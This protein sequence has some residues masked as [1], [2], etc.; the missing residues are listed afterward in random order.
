MFNFSQKHTKLTTLY[1]LGTKSED[2]SSQLKANSKRKK[3]V[4][5]VPTLATE[6]TLED[7]RP[8]F[9][10]ITRQLAKVTYL[11]KI[12]FG[13]DKAT[14]EEARELSGLLKKSGLRNYIIQHNEGEAF[15]SIYKTLNEAGFQLDQPGKGR[16]MFMSFG[17]AQAIGA[18]CIGVLDADIKTFH[19][20]QLDRLFYPVL[21]RDYEFSKAFYARIGDGKMYGR[22][23]RLLL[24]P[25]LLSLKRK[26]SDS[27]EDKFLRLVDYLLAFN[28]QLSGEVAF[29]T[30][31]LRRMHFATNW[32]VEIFTLIEVYRKA[33][34]VAQVQFSR[35]PFDHK[36][37]AVS[38]EDKDR[39]LYK[40]AIDI[41][42]TIFASL[43]IEEGLEIS[44]Y[45]IQ[46]L[47]ITYLNVADELI[48]K[49]ADNSA[50]LSLSYDRNAD[51]ALVRS[52]FKDAILTAG[53][54]LISP[55]RIT[56]RF[57]RVLLSDTRFHKYLDIGLDRDLM[58]YERDNMTQLF[59]VPQTVSWE[60]I[61]TK[62]PRILSSIDDAIAKEK[63]TYM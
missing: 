12:I 1:L 23:K 59:E 41:V 33:N 44:D 8:V 37:Q 4:L 36:H 9:M 18:R 49:Y 11:H 51:E 32:G 30:S 50:F 52:I 31:L 56:D 22:L 15:K 7:N 54:Y 21:V 6:F 24:D 53:D 61:I 28:Y 62:L 40:M 39:G 16:N 57:L 29:D 25:L 43:V 42:T 19:R 2:L 34:N 60:R 63:K 46:D 27:G 35:R 3:A 14:D 58:E 26:F 20:R 10:N 48:K 47:T 55:Y 38:I 13:L 5:V 17:I 45:F